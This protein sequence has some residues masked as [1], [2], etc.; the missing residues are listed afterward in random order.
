M[1]F[2]WLEVIGE[3]IILDSCIP[4]FEEDFGVGFVGQACVQLEAGSDGFAG[5]AGGEE[6]GVALVDFQEG[7]DGGM[8]QAVRGRAAGYSRRL[9]LGGVRSVSISLSWFSWV[10]TVAMLFQVSGVSVM[11]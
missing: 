6:I 3:G 5:R 1:H 7:A 8:A 10:A 2:V 11:P 9:Q 4:V